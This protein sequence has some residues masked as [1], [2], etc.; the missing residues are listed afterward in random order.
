M[1][2][3]DNALILTL[4]LMSHTVPAWTIAM[5]S[6][7]CHYMCLSYTQHWPTQLLQYLDL[8]IEYDSA[9]QH[10]PSELLEHFDLDTTGDQGRLT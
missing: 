4:P 8:D 3:R 10:R 6:W 9:K 1:L 2:N 5:K 7:P